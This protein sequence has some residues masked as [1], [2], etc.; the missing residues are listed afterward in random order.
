MKLQAQSRKLQAPSSKL[1]G[2]SKFQARKVDA[3]MRQRCLV[4]GVWCFFGAWSLV[5]GASEGLPETGYGLPTSV[6]PDASITKP[7]GRPRQNWIDQSQAQADAKSAG[8]NQ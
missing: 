8:C 5:L 7:A 4:L 6:S 1:Q 2:N 3:R